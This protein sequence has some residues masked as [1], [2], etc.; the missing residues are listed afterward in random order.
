MAANTLDTFYVLLT[1]VSKQDQE[2]FETWNSWGYYAVS[3]ELRTDDER[4][5]TITKKPVG[6]TRNGSTTFVISPDAQMVYP[7][8][9][10]KAWD[11]ASPLPTADEQPVDVTVKAI[12]EIKR[13][14]EST[15]QHVWTGRV[16]SM[17]YHFMFR[18]WSEHSAASKR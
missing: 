10:D 16:E 18:H 13:T 5:V 17:V 12:Y 7:N 9:L 1:N 15:Q 14:R 6:F 2:V 3:F 4:I 8:K 11:A